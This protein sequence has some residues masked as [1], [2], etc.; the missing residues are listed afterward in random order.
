MRIHCNNINKYREYRWKNNISS[1]VTGVESRMRYESEP[2]GEILKY[3]KDAGNTVRKNLDEKCYETKFD[4]LK[5][6]NFLL[7]QL[8]TTTNTTTS[9]VLFG[10]SNI[11]A[12]NNDAT[13]TIN[14]NLSGLETVP[15][16]TYNAIIFFLIHP[17]NPN[18]IISNQELLLGGSIP[19]S[20]SL[21]ANQ[22]FNDS[23]P[24]NLVI[25][26]Q[27]GNKIVKEFKNRYS[28]IN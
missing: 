10:S 15:R 1:V 26:F 3:T 21:K 2:I 19:N 12:V 6:F 5:D 17:N 7:N 14:F 27:K 24:I 16:N 20:I 13:Y 25:R 8:N 28:A 11:I 4:F 18:T 22:S 23:L 9:R